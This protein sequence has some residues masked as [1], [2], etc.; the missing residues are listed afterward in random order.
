MTGRTR[1]RG[2]RTIRG[3]GMRCALKVLRR[4]RGPVGA[5]GRTALLAYL[6]AALAT[7]ALAAAAG[8]QPDPSSGSGASTLQ[9]DAFPG[10]SAPA[11]APAASAAR[12]EP[13]RNTDTA[14][15][16]KQVPVAPVAT[17][18]VAAAPH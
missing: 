10:G 18:P 5:W 2:L 4:R 9:P 6:A 15:P 3:D 12:P 14:A 7:P 11:T 17:A 16:R 1:V 13:V 8:L